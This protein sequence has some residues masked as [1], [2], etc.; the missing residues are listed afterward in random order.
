MK[1]VRL[2]LGAVC[3][4]SL[5]ASAQAQQRIA[6]SAPDSMPAAQSKPGTAPVEPNPPVLEAA[7]PWRM[8]NQFRPPVLQCDKD[9]APYRAPASWLNREDPAPPADW[10]KAEFDDHRWTRGSALLHAQT[11]D[12]AQLCHPFYE[13]LATTGDH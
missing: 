4:W 11:S 8:Y 12:L 13:R 6:A 5:I 1:T 3:A 10:V 9:L 7:S 2:A